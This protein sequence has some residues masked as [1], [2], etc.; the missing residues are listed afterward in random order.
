MVYLVSRHAAAKAFLEAAG[1]PGAIFAE[2]LDIARIGAGDI[3]AGTLPAHL[4]AEVCQAGGRY[5]HLVLDLSPA[6]RGR[7]LS[8]EEMRK[9]GAKLIEIDARIVGEVRA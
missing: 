4:V 2:H 5:F 9:A 1:F 3:V 6:A 7:D 8:L